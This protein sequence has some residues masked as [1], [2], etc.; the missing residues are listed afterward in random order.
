MKSNLPGPFDGANLCS[1]TRGMYLS[2]GKRNGGESPYFTSHVSTNRSLEYEILSGSQQFHIFL[3]MKYLRMWFFA[4]P[5]TSVLS[6]TH[7][8]HIFLKI[9]VH[10]SRA[11]GRRGNWILYGDAWWLWALCR[12][13]LLP[14]RLEFWGDAQIFERF[15]HHCFKTYFMSHVFCLSK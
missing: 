4:S 6:A 12:T 14:L 10:K 2:R 1:C 7:R 15:V 13:C 8:R 5:C 9:G 11:P 3:K